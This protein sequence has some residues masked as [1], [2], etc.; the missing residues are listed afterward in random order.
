MRPEVSAIVVGLSLP[1]C[2]EGLAGE[3]RRE[4]IHAS[5]PASAVEGSKVVPDRSLM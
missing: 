3:S 2:A 1:G 5:T 4:E